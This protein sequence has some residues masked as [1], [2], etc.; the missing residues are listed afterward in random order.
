MKAIELFEK[1]FFLD[2]IISKNSSLVQR[3]G[4]KLPAIH[5]DLVAARFELL[6]KVRQILEEVDKD[7]NINDLP[8]VVASAINLLGKQQIP[9]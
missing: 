9:Q 2:T 5:I 6:R 7:F 1:M 4:C 3:T 8:P